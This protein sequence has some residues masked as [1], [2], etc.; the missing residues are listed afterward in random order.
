MKALKLSRN[1]CRAFAVAL[2]CLVL[3]LGYWMTVHAWF[4]APLMRQSEEIA[5]LEMSHQRFSRLAAQVEA[6]SARLAAIS[7]MPMAEGS[8]L[9]SFDPEIAKGQLMQLVLERSAH[10]SQS[11]LSCTVQNRVPAPVAIQGNL[12][13]ISLDVEIE[14]GPRALAETLHRLETE[15]PTLRV[16]G[17]SIQRLGAAVANG[18]EFQRWGGSFRVVGYQARDAG[19]QHD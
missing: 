12:S 10:H 3:V 16:D 8:L 18:S 14:C 5:L 7:E 2:A 1:A 19:R 9:T 15:S 17:L 4:V 13:R 11:G 6:V